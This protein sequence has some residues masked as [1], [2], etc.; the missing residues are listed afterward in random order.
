MDKTFDMH[1]RLLRAVYPANRRPDFWKDGKLSSA[2]LKDKK[3]LS[4]TRTY[5]RPLKDAVL[6]MSQHFQGTIVSI[7][8]ASCSAVQACVKYRPSQTNP[9]HSE[10][11]GSETQ[12]ELSDL[13][14]LILARQATLEYV[15]NSEY[16]I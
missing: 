9:Y 8:V 16:M 6:W 11:H 10:I 7:S 15:P 5:D 3:G 4:V 12:V 13:Q 14:A 1:E 2:A